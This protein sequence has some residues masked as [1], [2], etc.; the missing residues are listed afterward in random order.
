MSDLTNSQIIME[1]IIKRQS[2]ASEI[3]YEDYFETYSSMQILKDKDISYSDAEYSRVGNGGDGGI[4]TFF[5]FLNGELIK[6][7]TD[8]SKTSKNNLIEVFIIQ[9][10]T[11]KKF[12]ESAVVNLNESTRDLFNISQDIKTNKEIKLRYNIDLIKKISIFKDLYLNL[13]QSFPEV[14]FNYYY[15]TLGEGVHPKVRG[16]KQVLETTV[17]KL[18][19]G[20]EFNFEFVSATDL[21]ELSRKVKNTTRSME[22]SESPIATSSGSYLCLV[23]LEKYY[24]FISDKNDL[25]RSIFESNVRDYNGSVIVNDA[26]QKTLRN[27]DQEFWFLNNGVTVIS[28]KATLSGKTLTIENPQIVNG[29]QTS[30]EIYNFFST[31]DNQKNEK[32]NILVRVICEEKEDARDKIIRATNSQTSIPPASLRS[33]DSIHRDIEDYFKINGLFYDRRK[34]FY[35]NEGKP[36]SKIISISYL[37]QCVISTLLL[38]PDNARA[39]PST[40]I[41]DHKRYEMIFDKNYPMNLYLNCYRIVKHV[42][43]LMKN[44]V[45]L[46]RKDFNNLLYHTAM[47]VTMKYKKDNSIDTLTDTISNIDLNLIDYNMFFNTFNFV[48]EKYLELGGN[49]TVAKGPELVTVIKG[50]FS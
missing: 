50:H 42:E 21:L 11:S 13:M 40:L 10:K 6:E 14:R 25:S 9:S 29:L 49:D 3:K 33:A 43:N 1:T 38:Q 31:T 44:I 32:R 37:A 7:D 45:T 15:S 24:D 5:T 19:T 8:Y 46:E 36:V 48:L 20:S 17:K 26:I 39:R 28:S 2:E 41:N 16:K 12:S 22:L 4:D 23:N 47:S 34:N 27:A 18:F 35:R 30:H